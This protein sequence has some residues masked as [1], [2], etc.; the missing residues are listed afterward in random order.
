MEQDYFFLYKEDA[1]SFTTSMV[2]MLK[3]S[4]AIES[5]LY[6]D[7]C[8]NAK[9]LELSDEFKAKLGWMIGN[10]Y[11]RVGTTD[12]ES[13]MTAEQR[14]AMLSQELNSHCIIGQKNQIKALK[15]AMESQSETIR[16]KDD[17]IKFISEFHIETQYEQVMKV[18]EEIINTSSNDIPKIEKD[19]IIKTI[20][21]RQILK[22]LLSQKSSAD[23]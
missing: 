2:A 10:I 20:R 3:V 11:S 13:I 9:F 17:A 22:T 16:T 4:I 15:K 21:S 1:L 7:M 12:W 8:L 19:R 23:Q 6:Y 14:K 5:D 18:L